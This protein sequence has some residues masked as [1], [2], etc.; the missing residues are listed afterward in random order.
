MASIRLYGMGHCSKIVVEV[1]PLQRDAD[2]EGLSV[3][4]VDQAADVVVV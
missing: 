1:V 4:Q 2:Q 3:P